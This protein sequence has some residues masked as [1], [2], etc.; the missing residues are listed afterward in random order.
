MNDLMTCLVN[1][2]PTRGLVESR[3]SRDETIASGPRS[4]WSPWEGLWRNLAPSTRIGKRDSS[5]GHPLG[6]TWFA[7]FPALHNQWSLKINRWFHAVVFGAVRQG[8]SEAV[9]P[10]TVLVGVVDIEE[11]GLEHRPFVFPDIT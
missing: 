7:P 11:S 6:G 2:R 8:H 1:P 4:S 3:T 9:E 5:N 10:Q